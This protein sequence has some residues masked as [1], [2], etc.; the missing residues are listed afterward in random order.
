MSEWT[1][2]EDG[3]RVG[4]AGGA[5]DWQAAWSELAFVGLVRSSA[6][7][8]DGGM[9][10][11]TRARRRDGPA[12]D[13][14][15]YTTFGPRSLRWEAPAHGHLVSVGHAPATG[16]L[17]ETHFG[18]LTIVDPDTGRRLHGIAT[19]ESCQTPAVTRRDL[20]LQ[21]GSGFDVSITR[22][23]HPR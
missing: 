9:E 7:R 1:F 12:L 8:P 11:H 17:Y 13:D 19:T 2:D 21:Q 4:P 5:A 15:R 14:P 10:L 22:L 16:L 18:G 3:L 6:Q 23:R 20:Y